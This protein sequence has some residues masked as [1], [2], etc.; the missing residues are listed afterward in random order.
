[1]ITLRPYQQTGLSD[2]R[3]AY[4][5]GARRVCYTLPTGGGKTVMFSR[6]A[7]LTAARGR[8]VVILVHRD[9]LVTQIAAALDREGTPHGLCVA[10]RCD[11]AP[12]T[13][14]SVFTLARRL[15]TMTPPD[16]IVI[17]ECHHAVA[18][19]WRAVSD[20]WPAAW[21]L[22]V[23]ATPCR[24]DGR[25]LADCFDTLVSGPT[26]PDLIASGHL[27]PPVVYAPPSSLSLSG[28]R[29]T[30]G[31]YNRADLRAA[32]ERPVL[33]GEAVSN[34]MRLAA[35]QPAI[36]FCASVDHARA[37]ADAFVAAGVS[38]ASIDGEMPADARR[39]RVAA[40]RD[41]TL[42]VLTSCDLVS[43]G[44]DVPGVHAA[45]MCRPTRSLGLF[46]Q[47]AGRAMR[48]APGKAHATILDHAG[49]CLR[50]G[51][52]SE[53]REWE[54]TATRKRAG[55]SVTVR[56]CLEC[57]RCFN[58]VSRACPY[59]GWEAPAKPRAAVRQTDGDL[60]AVDPADERWRA[61][62]FRAALREARDEAGLRAMA[63]ARGY[64][65]GWVAGVLRARGNGARR[66]HKGE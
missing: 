54:L 24:L 10:G 18:G 62:T 53:A 11:D 47:M 22:G 21:T 38:A 4:R 58:S 36:A 44:F 30:A 55:A 23:T 42:T 32:L 34:Y 52:P 28:V 45:L 8:R 61:L 13:I 1:M 66:H 12:V 16:L 27:A 15:S 35:G 31:D 7:S 50:H 19:S 9:E 14:A 6:L 51:L 57:Y 5:A 37:V 56:Q 25:G 3:A 33:Y 26:V 49:N 29:T 17:D 20:A 46:L 63:R 41:G 60:A 43:E 48:P 65:P 2:I 64:R 39:A 59:C 40:L